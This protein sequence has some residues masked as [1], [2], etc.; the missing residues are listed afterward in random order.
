MKTGSFSDALREEASHI[1]EKIFEHPFLAEMGEGS[2]PLDKFRYYVKQDYAYLVE[3]A[4]CLG[5]AGAKA[6]DLETMRALADL[7]RASLTVEIEMLEGLCER[8]GITQEELREAEAAPTNFAYTR[9]LLHVAY[10]G[11][12]GEI[13]ASMLPCMWSYQLIG[14]RMAGKTEHPIFGDWCAT[15]TSKEY[16]DLVAWFRNL[17]DRCAEGAG[18]VIRERMRKHFVLSSM[19]EYMFWEMAY[20]E[21]EWPV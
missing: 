19:Y 13:M 17:T 14:E 2:L 18:D 6:D 15:Y 10:S 3:F 1:W 8:I 5:L 20:N 12:V 21:E 4:R 16:A 11:T 7:F 9:H